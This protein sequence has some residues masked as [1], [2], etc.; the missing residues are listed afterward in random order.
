RRYNPTTF[1]VSAST[2]YSPGFALKSDGGTGKAAFGFSVA[3]DPLTGH[4]YVLE[5][6]GRTYI[7]E[8]N[9]DGSFFRFFE[10][11]EDDT[12]QGG[13]LG[14]Y[15]EGLAVVAGGGTYYIA[16]NSVKQI[17]IYGPPPPAAPVLAETA[18]SEVSARSARLLAEINPNVLTTSYRFQYG[19]S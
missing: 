7:S 17:K 3:H 11:D 12:Y 18:A 1:P 16:N 2:S 15:S 19:L 9:S 10:R 4:V 13:F 14:E 6:Y 8:F 5:G